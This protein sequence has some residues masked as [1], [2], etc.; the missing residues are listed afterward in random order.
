MDVTGSDAA[1]ASSLLLENGWDLE[2]AVTKFYMLF[3]HDNCKV[4]EKGIRAPIPSV[5]QKLVEEFVSTNDGAEIS[6]NHSQ[7]V[8]KRRRFRKEALHASRKNKSLYNNTV[9][10]LPKKTVDLQS[11]F[12]P[13]F[14]IMF[15]GSFQDARR[16]AMLEK[17][18]L[19]V[20][21]QKQSEF[22]SHQLNRD[23]WRDDTVQQVIA[24]SYIFWM[25]YTEDP[26]GDE[27]AR[28]YKVENFPHVAIIDPRTGG[29][30]L[31][32]VNRRLVSVKIMVEKIQGFTE[33][34]L[35]FG[36][37][38]AKSCYEEPYFDANAVAEQK[39][40]KS[41]EKPPIGSDNSDYVPSSMGTN[42]L[43]IRFRMKHKC[44]DEVALLHSDDSLKS[45]M[46]VNDTKEKGIEIALKFPDGKRILKKY[47]THDTIRVIY[48]YVQSVL[49]QAVP[50]FELRTIYP[51]RL[52]SNNLDVSVKSMRIEG[53]SIMVKLC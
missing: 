24:C 10:D 16:H 33:K 39:K 49:G 13:P 5:R 22:A 7:H 47:N 51:P 43:P 50:T 19:L 11:L 37:N 2:A 35:Y 26:Y 53:S 46:G 18:F 21:I 29:E 48:N 12:S 17:K 34:R 3:D 6:I 25:A 28:N 45:K 1:L 8:R 41:I 36:K 31:I 52:L 27:Y 30:E 42:V 44:Q 40:A 23:V 15:A 32:I 9:N 38:K 20:N 14:K 4:S